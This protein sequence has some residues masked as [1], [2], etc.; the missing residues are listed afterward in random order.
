MWYRVAPVFLA[1]VGA[2]CQQRVARFRLGADAGT[3]ARGLR[4]GDAFGCRSDRLTTLGAASPSPADRDL[5]S[6]SEDASHRNT[7]CGVPLVLP[8][9][10]AGGKCHPEGD[11]G[12]SEKTDWAEAGQG[13]FE[14]MLERFVRLEIERRHAIGSWPEGEP[15]MSFQV[16]FPEDNQPVVRLNREIQ[17]TARAVVAR[18]VKA[19]EEI[20]HDDI[21]GISGYRPPPEEADIAHVTAFAHRGGWSVAFSFVRGH[22]SRHTCLEMGQEFL[23]TAKEALADGRLGPCFDTAFSAAELLAKAELLSCRP[24]VDLVLGSR[25]HDAVRSHYHLWARLGKTADRFPKLL[26]RLTELRGS[27]RYLD[28]RIELSIDEARDTVATLEAMEEHVRAVVTGEPQ[29]EIPHGFSVDATRPVR[30]GELVRE[31]DF[32]IRPPKPAR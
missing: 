29:G 9:E 2:F 28:D 25:K 10:P 18:T 19:G 8:L 30:A 31:E 1:L 4:R 27:A 12:T 6:D 7:R 23:A 3:V 15:V 22:P 20:A 14:D 24:T 5:A 21:S 13:L 17:G 26:S 11:G 16:V 32:S